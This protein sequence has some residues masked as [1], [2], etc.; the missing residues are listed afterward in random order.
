[1]LLPSHLDESIPSL[2]ASVYVMEISLQESER[3]T[4][5]LLME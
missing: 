2:V 3:I 4:F 5:V 1:M